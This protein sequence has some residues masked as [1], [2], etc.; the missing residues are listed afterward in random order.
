V[1]DWVPWTNPFERLDGHIIPGPGARWERITPPGAGLVPGPKNVRPGFCSRRQGSYCRIWRAGR[2]VVR[3]ADKRHA[4]RRR[5]PLP[6]K[7]G[8]GI[9]DFLA[10]S[11]RPWLGRGRDMTT[12]LASGLH[13]TGVQATVVAGGG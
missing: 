2:L 5:L 7:L 6:G 13:L 8:H 9:V 1:A 3:V 4:A 10:G 12:T 11:R